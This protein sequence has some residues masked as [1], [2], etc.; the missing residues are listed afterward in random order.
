M[1]RTKKGFFLTIDTHIYE[2]PVKKRPNTSSNKTQ[3]PSLLIFP[4]WPILISCQSPTALIKSTS[5]FQFVA[6]NLC[7]GGLSSKCCLKFKITAALFILFKMD[8]LPHFHRGRTPVRPSC[9]RRRPQIWQ[10]A[11]H[12]RFH[13]SHISIRSRIGVIG[14]SCSA[15]TFVECFSC[16]GWEAACGGRLSSKAEPREVKSSSQCEASWIHVAILNE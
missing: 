16:R 12:N 2:H 6:S 1:I 15:W 5:L 10:T 14:A 4:S 13:A 3:C 9:G 11:D 7:G 8:I